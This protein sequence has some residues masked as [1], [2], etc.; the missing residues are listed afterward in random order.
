MHHLSDWNLLRA[1]L[2]VT[3]RLD[4]DDAA[5]HLGLS[6]RTLTRRLG[7]LERELDLRLLIRS[8]SRTALTPAGARLRDDLIGPVGDISAAL[9]NARRNRPV[10]ALRIVISTDLPTA[11][12]DRVRDW[13]HQHG[14]PAIVELRATPAIAELLASGLADLALLLGEP[15]GLPGMVV[16][17]EPTAVAVPADHPAARET[18]IAA[19]T[20]D[21]LPIVL[22]ETATPAHRRIVSELLRGQTQPG[23]SIAAPI[24]A[25]AD[26]G[27]LHAARRH[28]AAALVLARNA[29]RLDTTGLAIRP[30]EPAHLAPVSLVGRSQVP[31]E[32]VR[33]LAEELIGVPGL[34]PG[35]GATAPTEPDAS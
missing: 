15:P 31:L 2:V 23:P 26:A 8:G 4:R 35:D 22:P 27:M 30:L 7:Q 32:Q 10:T 6:A 20:I 24:V 5:R 14:R 29:R 16:G 28:R 18:V 21:D 34:A 12:G 25:T 33:T 3:G 1:F 19:G 17:H 13:I 11:W 9:D